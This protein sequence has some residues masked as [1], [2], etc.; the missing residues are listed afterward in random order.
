MDA[1]AII[2]WTKDQ[3]GLET[4]R[5]YRGLLTQAYIDLCN[6]PDRPGVTAPPDI[7]PGISLYP[8]RY[9]LP[10]M[11]RGDR[12]GSARHVVAF[13]FDDQELRVA[14]LLHD[15]MDIPAR[16]RRNAPD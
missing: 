10:R 11:V 7:E 6:A 9:S 8:I 16:L 4:A 14:R 2:A 15:S 12:V 3:F 1:V 5:R 13:S